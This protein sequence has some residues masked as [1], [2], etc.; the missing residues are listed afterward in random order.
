MK[1]QRLAQ[2]L[3]AG[4]LLFWVSILLQ[5]TLLVSADEASC[6]PQDVESG[7]CSNSPKEWTDEVGD[8][9]Q[10]FLQG[11]IFGQADVEESSDGDLFPQLEQRGK[12]GT[13][14]ANTDYL[15]DNPILRLFGRLTTDQDGQD[16]GPGDR[17]INEDNPLR[18]LMDR[19][20]EMGKPGGESSS[21][22]TD[23]SSTGRKEGAIYGLLDKVKHLDKD[24]HSIV[25]PEFW[26]TIQDALNRAL[27]QLKN[28]FGHILDEV[29]TSVAISMVYYLADEDSRKNPSWKRQQHRFCEKVSKSF[30]LELHDA[31]YLSQLSYVD[32]IDEFKKGL[33]QFHNNEWEMAYGSTD[34]LPSL[35]A[36]FLAVHKNL[37]PLKNPSLLSILPW[38]NKK[39]SELTVLLIVRGTK[40]LSD[41]LADALLEPAEYRGGYAHGGILENGKNLAARYLPKLKALLEH[42]GREKI[43][44]YLVGHSLG[45]GA[46]AI[47]AIEFNDHE[48]I[49]VES[50]GF[51]CPSLLSRELSEASKDYVTTVVADSDIIPRMSGASMANLLLDL[52]EFDWTKMALDDVDFTIER[53]KATL[54]FGHLLPSKDVILDWVKTHIERDVKP[55]LKHDKRNRVSHILIPPGDCVHFYRDGIGYSG[56]YTPCTFF[57]N[58]DV[59][60]TLV[61]DHLVVPGYHR[62]LI[63]II[64]DL[65][66]DFNVS[67]LERNALFLGRPPHF[68]S[69]RS[70]VSFNLPV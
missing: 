42:S 12:D 18:T 4:M 10:Q 60:R 68:S 26:G 52:I 5:V 14:N 66:N 17:T 65:E 20:S 34:S 51:G 49:E 33:A 48:W 43:R 29:D 41:A 24:D 30:I 9:F 19:L 55:K 50:V 57:D 53:A 15:V 47:A 58:V 35:P 45:A 59:S 11:K 36:H 54:P 22:L 31:L 69:R 46:A 2:V 25:G 62:A 67:L 44:L 39:D 40:D 8:K 64:R 63:S 27:E 32:S 21:S 70:L 37:S 56:V 28:T 13:V 16:K 7:A 23:A 1:T 3:I 6:S 61:D 38:E